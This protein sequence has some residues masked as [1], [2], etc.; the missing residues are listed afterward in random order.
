MVQSMAA[1]YRKSSFIVGHVR[2]VA[3][4]FSRKESV[5]KFVDADF[6]QFLLGLKGEVVFA[7]LVDALVDPLQPIHEAMPLITDGVS[8][9]GAH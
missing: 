5:V 6:Q 7:R 9:G 3:G 1:F 4:R 8:F 2:V